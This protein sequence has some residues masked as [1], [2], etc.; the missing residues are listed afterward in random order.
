M[1][2]TE[3]QRT[4]RQRGEAG[5][6]FD[7]TIQ[8]QQN[9]GGSLALEGMCVSALLRLPAQNPPYTMRELRKGLSSREGTAPTSD[10]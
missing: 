10:E 5:W 9:E 8:P 6:Y 7:L 3:G 1:R 2:R 4:G